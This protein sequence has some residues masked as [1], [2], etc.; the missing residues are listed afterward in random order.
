M[1]TVQTQD[2]STGQDARKGDIAA[3]MAWFG[4]GSVVILLTLL[5]R[6][7]GSAPLTRFGPLIPMCLGAYGLVLGCEKM[8]GGLR[9]VIGST[10]P[11]A[12]A[13]GRLAMLLCLLLVLA[14]VGSGAA[15]WRLRAPYW[16]AISA[17]NRGDLAA[18][19]LRAIAERHAA[20]IQASTT[21]A[22]AL[23]SWKE[24]AATALPLRPD[25]AAAL[26]AARYLEAAGGGLRAQAEIDVRFYALCLEWMDLYESVQRAVHD[27]SMTDPPNEWS[28]KLDGIIE[29][30]QALPQHPQEKS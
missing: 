4:A 11:S 8:F 30:I 27:A 6:V 17:R 23:Q 10:D 16:N 3:G 13:R 20:A 9:R 28:E 2:T 5:F 7:G 25:F 22:D 19:R 18:A 26:E 14:A 29:R 24:T 1:P 15:V 21:G 12:R